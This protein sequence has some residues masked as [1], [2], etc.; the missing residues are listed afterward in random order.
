[1]ILGHDCS[2]AIPLPHKVQRDFR[3][4]RDRPGTQYSE[5]EKGSV[6]ARLEAFFNQSKEAE[7]KTKDYAKQLKMERLSCALSV[8]SLDHALRADRRY[9]VTPEEMPQAFRASQRKRRACVENTASK[10]RRLELPAEALE[11]PTLFLV[12]DQGSSFWPAL[13]WLYGPL[14]IRGAF[15]G[16]ECHRYWNDTLQAIKDSGLWLVFCEA[17]IVSGFKGGPWGGSAFFGVLNEAVDD[18]AGG[19]EVGQDLIFHYLFDELAKDHHMTDPGDFGTL[20]HAE[21]LRKM[22][23]SSLGIRRKGSKMK[24]A[25]W[26]SWFKSMRE[27]VLPHWYSLLWALLRISLHHGWFS[28]VDDISLSAKALKEAAHND[29]APEEMPKDADASTHSGSAPPTVRESNRQTQELRQSSKNTLHLVAMVFANRAIRNQVA[30]MVCVAGA[31]EQDFNDTVALMKTRDGTQ[32]HWIQHSSGRYEEKLFKVTATLTDKSVLEDMRFNEYGPVDDYLGLADD[33]YLAERMFQFVMK[34]LE[35]RLL[36]SISMGCMFPGRVASLCSSDADEV[37]QCLCSLKKTWEFLEEAERI[38]QGDSWMRGF[39]RQCVWPQWVW[40]REMLLAL[41][42][43]NWE[44]VPGV[45]AASVLK[46]MRCPA[47]TKIIEDSVNCA[48]DRARSSK[49]GKCGARGVWHCLASG[50]LAGSSDKPPVVPSA[51]SQTA[52]AATQKVL[53]PMMFVGDVGEASISEEMGELCGLASWA[54]PSPQNFKVV[55]L[56]WR[57]WEDLGCVDKL[58]QAWLSQVLMPGTVV[59]KRGM[60]RAGLVLRTTEFGA[61]FWG[62]T[63][64]GNAKDPLLV[65]VQTSTQDDPAWFQ[66]AAT[67]LEGWKAAE[68][69]ALPPSQVALKQQ[70]SGMKLS[71]G[72]AL[73]TV[74][75][76]ESV[77]KVAARMGFLGMTTS[78]M[79]KLHMF[80]WGGERQRKP[81][82]EGALCRALI[83]HAFPEWSV[84]Q[85][86]AAVKRRRPDLLPARSD[87]LEAWDVKNGRSMADD[88]MVDE[89]IMAKRK[90]AEKRASK[91]SERSSASSARAASGTSSQPSAG[92]AA[93]SSSRSP[94]GQPP[95]AS[96]A[97]ASRK[98][99]SLTGSTTPEYA[100]QL[101]PAIKGC[102][103]LCDTV[104]HNRWQVRYPGSAPPFSN[105]KSWNDVVSYDEALR[106]VLRWVWERHEAETGE[107]CTFSFGR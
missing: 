75:Q 26:L 61:V 101:V 59:F 58:K 99:V 82:G 10:M 62:V 85:V 104:R 34:L 79:D 14:G 74:R 20:A 70:A 45:V 44:E 23:L 84:E 94:D 31:L 5:A 24:V 95:P 43:N 4:R 35:H 78:L 6:L 106:T 1:M 72:V 98:S 27:D 51:S 80:L 11:S 81:V 25:R 30:M 69:R 71:P 2:L 54:S 60:H 64:I 63:V 68:V 73:C 56:F 50:R 100:K 65:P 40:P 15:W 76:P 49:S 22:V 12:P 97:S 57:A 41:L 86:D 42:E 9:F 17:S 37:A 52:A 3:W 103:I 29:E 67:S 46:F 53:P 48:K 93:S 66:M 28:S 91:A 7:A 36:S 16:D 89:I 87:V 18:F 47:S 77:L 13:F 107:A 32:Q 83:L 21:L 19:V 39:L 90:L 8:Q 105:A 96:A 55:A 88:D 102:V 33:N 92:A 38:A